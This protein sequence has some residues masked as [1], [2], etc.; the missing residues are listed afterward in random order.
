[1]FTAVTNRNLKQILNTF[2]YKEFTITMFIAQTV[3]R[4]FPQRWPGFEPGVWS[5]GICVDR[6]ALGQ[7]F[8]E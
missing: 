7:V 5:N 6:V 2:L 4:G 1:M 8:S 3:S